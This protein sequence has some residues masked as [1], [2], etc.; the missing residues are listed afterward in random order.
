MSC[1]I[2]HEF[3]VF[4]GGRLGPLAGIYCIIRGGAVQINLPFSEV[5]RET[6]GTTVPM[7]QTRCNSQ[8]ARSLPPQVI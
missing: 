1:T 8:S 2:Y 6:Y 4:W 3:P 5:S 7:A